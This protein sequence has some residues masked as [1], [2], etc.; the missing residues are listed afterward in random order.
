M[1]KK[2]LSHSQCCHSNAV[3]AFLFISTASLLSIL[4]LRTLQ[5]NVIDTYRIIIDIL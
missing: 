1:I 4:D 3:L 5:S 2:I